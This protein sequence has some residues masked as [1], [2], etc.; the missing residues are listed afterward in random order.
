MIKNFNISCFIF[1]F[2]FI[3]SN[4]N[5]I[6]KPYFNVPSILSQKNKNDFH[7]DQ[8]YSYDGISKLY[9]Q[10][11]VEKIEEIILIQLDEY[12]ESYKNVFL[13]NSNT[14]IKYNLHGDVSCS[15]KNKKIKSVCPYHYEVI[16]RKDIYPHRRVFTVCNCKNCQLVSYKFIK[17]TKCEP[18]TIPMPA[19]KKEA[20]KWEFIFEKV[21][22]GCE[23]VLNIRD[24]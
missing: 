17:S 19:L 20:N 18:I 8:K 14:G 15:I 24:Y 6:L 23:C 1:Y 16:F 13:N 3:L 5:K 10:N 21:S 7:T 4:T 9:A 2:A 12:K 11:I 22:V